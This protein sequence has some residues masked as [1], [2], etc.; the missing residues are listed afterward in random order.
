[1]DMN[2]KL[3]AVGD[4]AVGKTCL[5]W[6]Y[7]F[8][9]FPEDYIP[10]VFDNY[11]ANVMYGSQTITI[12]MWDTAGQDDYDRLRPLSYPDTNVFI[13]CYSVVSRNSFENVRTKWAPEVKHYCPDVPIVLVGTKADLRE[14]PDVVRRLNDKNQTVITHEEGIN[15]QLKTGAC[16]FLE[17]SARTQHNLKNMFNECIKS[18]VE[19]EQEKKKDQRKKL[20]CSIC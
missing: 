9:R 19:P 14:D 12:S 5:L 8:D 3:V 4:G 18:V 1:M 20:K 2:L 6:S 10:T 13:V 7:A 16:A 11:N 15:M 17:V